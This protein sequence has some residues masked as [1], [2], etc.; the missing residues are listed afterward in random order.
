MSNNPWEQILER[1][2]GDVILTSVGKIEPDKESILAY[3]KAKG[4]TLANVAEHLVDQ[5]LALAQ[6][7]FPV[8]LYRTQLIAGVNSAISDMYSSATSQEGPVFDM[9]M[10]WAKSQATKL[11]A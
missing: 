4:L 7:S 8:S 2:I 11:G 9:V 5:Q 3:I 1:A 10:G 6:L